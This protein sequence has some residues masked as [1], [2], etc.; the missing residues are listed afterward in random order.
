M[1]PE[2]GVCFESAPKVLLC[3]YPDLRVQRRCESCIWDVLVYLSVHVWTSCIK[4]H[5]VCMPCH[6][7]CFCL[8]PSPLPPVTY[9]PLSHVSPITC[10]PIMSLGDVPF[11]P[12]LYPCHMCTPCH[13]PPSHVDLLSHVFLIVIFRW[14]VCHRPPT[15]IVPLSLII[16]IMCAL[17]GWCATD[18]PPNLHCTL[19][20]YHMC[21]VCSK[22]VVCHRDPPNL[23]CSNLEFLLHQLKFLSLLHSGKITESLA[24]AKI[25]GQFAPRHTDGKYIPTRLHTYIHAYIHTYIHAYTHVHA[26]MNTYVHTHA[27]TYLCSGSVF[28]HG[29][30]VEHI[31]IG[32]Y[33]GNSRV[34]IVLVLDCWSFGNSLRW[35]W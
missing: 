1:D 33:H 34:A 22:W 30:F 12:P 6:P 27:Y 7:I 29:Y 2:P 15:F 21:H 8:Q 26:C 5:Y 18:I 3:S 20:P 14:V 11:Y 19:I 31:K 35:V 25:L 13:V 9:V 32:L 4:F 24:Y 10:V 23:H 16:C 17:G 28:W